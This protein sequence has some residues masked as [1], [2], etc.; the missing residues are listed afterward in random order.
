MTITLSTKICLGNSDILKENRYDSE[1]RRKIYSYIDTAFIYVFYHLMNRV[2]IYV[3][4]DFKPIF[5]SG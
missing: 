5:R 3:R 2:Q 4:N 1:I